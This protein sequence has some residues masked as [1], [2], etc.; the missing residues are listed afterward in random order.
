MDLLEDARQLADTVAAGAPPPV[1]A[2]PC[3]QYVKAAV[4][5][6]VPLLMDTLLKQDEDADAED[7][8]WNLSMSA[9]T[10]LG[11]VAGTVEDI[12]VPAVMPF[13]EQN[14][15]SENWLNREAATMAFS[16]PSTDPASTS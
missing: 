12:I 7:E 15:Q 4:E 8:I 13:V 6:L 10:C 11:L 9:S 3:M 1:P 14:I 2:R 5:H 16:V